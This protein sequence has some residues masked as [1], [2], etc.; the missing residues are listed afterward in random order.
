MGTWQYMKVNTVYLL[1][2]ICNLHKNVHFRV[3]YLIITE[4][5]C[6]R[7]MCYELCKGI[8]YELNTA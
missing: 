1:V 8:N 2:H 5:S 3:Q 6:I 7:V 4:A